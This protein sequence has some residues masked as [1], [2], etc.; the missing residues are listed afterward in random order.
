M[1]EPDAAGR[2]ADL[3]GHGLIAAGVVNDLSMASH[4]QS[5]QKAQRAVKCLMH[6]SANYPSIMETMGD[7]P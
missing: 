3:G 5:V 6:S 2:L 7:K 4:G 1:P